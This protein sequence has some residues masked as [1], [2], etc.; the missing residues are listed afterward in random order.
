MNNIK[1]LRPLL[2]NLSAGVILAGIG[3][4]THFDY[5]SKLI[6]ATGFGLACGALVHIFRF[7]YW[8]NPKRQK[9]YESRKEE[10]RINSIDE[11][12]QFLRMKSG[13]IIYHLMFFVLLLLAWALALFRA[14]G[15]VIG[16]VF[17]LSIFH[18]GAGTVAFRV[19]EKRL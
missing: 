15:W 14:D 19:L 17:V 13:Y 7:L 4:A 11:R 2:T 6:F 16:M 10:A 12:K 1:E 5:Y 18:W 8:K 3:L 9:E